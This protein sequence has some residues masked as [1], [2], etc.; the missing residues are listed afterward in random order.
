MRGRDAPRLDVQPFHQLVG[1]GQTGDVEL[2]NRGGDHHR[3]TGGAQPPNGVDRAL[4]ASL[5]PP[6]AVVGA[7]P[8]KADLEGRSETDPPDALQMLVGHEQAVGKDLAE[9]DLFLRQQLDDVQQVRSQERL[10]A[11]QR[12]LEDVGPL[13]LLDQPGHRLKRE[14]AVSPAGRFH[15]AV[16][17][18]QVAPARH[19]PMDSRQ[20]RVIRL[21]VPLPGLDGVPLLA[22]LCDPLRN[23][24]VEHSEVLGEKRKRIEVGLAVARLGHVKAQ[25]LQLALV[26]VLP[27]DERQGHVAPATEHP[28]LFQSR[29]LS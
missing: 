22:F 2:V 8:V 1:V 29:I 25:V 19:A 23:Q 16:P 9:P 28:V 11:G 3:K 4:F 14:L 27:V 10:A 17:A 26:A 24:Q 20:P 5:Y 13:E 21:P 15:V 12:N 18:F 6:H 7:H